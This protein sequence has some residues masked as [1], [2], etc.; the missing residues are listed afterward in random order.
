MN[1]RLLLTVGAL[2]AAASLSSCSTFKSADV[3]ARVN[4]KEL[5]RAELDVITAKA[6]GGDEA[7]SVIGDWIRLAVLGG[8]LIG[9]AS[10]DDLA[11][12]RAQAVIDL[13]SPYMGDA[14]TNYAKG[15]DGSPAL[16]LGAIPMDAGADTAAVLA[17][18][19]AGTTWA[20][21]AKKYSTNTDFAQNGGL[22]LDQSGANCVAP[23]VF[24]PELIDALTTAK[25]TIG[26]PVVIDV[27][28]KPAVVLLRPFEDLTP[29][30]RAILVQ[31][32]VAADLSKRLAATTIYVNPRFGR[33][34]AKSVSVVALGT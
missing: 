6:T 26:N 2:V 25:A 9:V 18:L 23:S 7:R 10:K 14:A 20:D 33:W 31:P 21:A 11:A 24:K 15:L 28:G 17:D 32:Q 34:D 19:A 4:G 16:C 12:R 27:G 13:S 8:D 1:R 29:S 3:A 5:P 22:V 30:D